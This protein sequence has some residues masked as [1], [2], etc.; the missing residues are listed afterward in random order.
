MLGQ[1]I[2]AGMFGCQGAQL[3][4]DSEATQAGAAAPEMAPLGQSERV[5]GWTEVVPFDSLQPGD[6]A[7][8]TEVVLARGAELLARLEAQGIPAD[9]LLAVLEKFHDEVERVYTIAGHFLSVCDSNEWR[10][11]WSNVQPTLTAF[12]SDFGQ[13]RALLDPLVQLRE[14]LG[15][16]APAHTRRLLDGLIQDMELSGVGLEAEKRK[17]FG[18]IQVELAQLSTTFAQNSLDARNAWSMVL[19][20]EAEVVGLSML[21]RQSAAA[22]ARAAGFPEATAETGPWRVTLDQSAASVVLQNAAHRPLREAVRRG[23]LRVAADGPHANEDTVARILELRRESAELLGFASYAD[24]S[25]ARKMAK[26]DDVVGLLERIVAS[27][28][29]AGQKDVAALRALAAKAGAPEAA[30]FAVWDERYWAE[31]DREANV[32][33]SEDELKLYFSFPRVLEGLFALVERLFG[34]RF[35]AAPDLPVWHPDVAAFRMFDVGEEQHRALLYVDAYARPATKRSGAWMYPLVSRSVA[36]GNGAARRPSAVICCNQM[37]PVDGGP[38]LMAF[39]EVTTLFH[40]LGH[41]LHHLF[42]ESDDARQA[43]IQGVEWDAVEVPSVFLESWVYH[44]P[45]LKQLARHHETGEPLP[46]STIDR[47][48]SA[49]EHQG[50]V[51]LLSQ[52]AYSLLDI[53]IHRDPRLYSAAGVDG[54]QVSQFANDVLGS[55][56]PMPPLPDDRML[57]SFGHLFAGGYA[58]GYY[59]YMWAGVMA[60]D[61]FSAFEAV[62]GEPEAEA[63]LGRRWRNLV[64][65]PGGSVHPLDL[66]VAFRGRPPSEAAFLAWYGVVSPTA[67]QAE[68][69]V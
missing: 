51:S 33:V 9:Q 38:A 12:L 55:V 5:F 52:A 42:A 43:G 25:L 68:V 46:D 26:K 8:A 14:D 10:S 66:F 35:V 69:Q 57:C 59:S 1:P 58:A 61:A 39:R 16:H 36:L 44:R 20:E 19:H 54:A 41:A 45:T 65:A 29:V 47:L 28:A 64:L 31:R 62:A 17:R 56:R 2:L 13:R 3:M 27:S 40:E 15:E 30:D 7:A 34:V 22:G 4:L 23:W 60:R 49:R 6:V 21:W 48:I 11:V 67:A 32:Q 63:S 18:E 53:A 50:A 24:L 37:A